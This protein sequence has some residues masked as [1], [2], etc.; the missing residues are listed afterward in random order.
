MAEWTLSAQPQEV[1]AKAKRIANPTEKIKALSSRRK[2]D[3]LLKTK[4]TVKERRNMSALG[5]YRSHPIQD[6]PRPSQSPNY[7]KRV[8]SLH[9]LP[10]VI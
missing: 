7:A 4:G 6:L 5:E 1:C 2:A 8:F 10:N 3:V 9:S